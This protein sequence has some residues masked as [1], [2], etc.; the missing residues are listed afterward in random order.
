MND[1]RKVVLLVGPDGSGKTTVADGLV[2]EVGGERLHAWGPLRARQAERPAGSPHVDLPYGRALSLAK[3]PYLYTR[4]LLFW[5]LRIRPARR[6]GLVVVERGWPDLLVDPRRYRLDVPGSLPRLLG[7][8]LPRPDLVAVLAVEPG[9]AVSR[10]GE[11]D[12]AEVERQV[13]AWREL[14]G[15][16]DG[17]WLVADAN[18]APRDVAG[19]IIRRLDQDLDERRPAL[20]LRCIGGP[21]AAG[22]PYR[23]VSRGGRPRWLLPARRGAAGPLRSGLYRPLRARQAIAARALDAAYALGLAG[24]KLLADPE[25]GLAPALREALGIGELEIAAATARK[26]GGER[27]LLAVR[28]S[29]RL[30]A[31]AKVG[32]VNVGGLARERSVLEALERV[33]L[34]N[35]R[36]PRVLACL[37]WEGEQVLVLE[38]LLS[39]GLADREPARPEQAA[40]AEL[41]SLGDA[42]AP[43][44]GAEDGLVP[45]HGDFA[46]WN[47]AALSGERLAVWDWEESRLGLPL[48]DLFHWRT[49]RVVLL[50]AGTAAELVAGA[51]HPDSDLRALCSELGVDPGTAPLALRAYLERGVADPRLELAQEEALLVR[52][53]ALAL[54]TERA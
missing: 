7:R 53:E 22:K 8:L 4:A 50:G 29:G 26:A 2:A 18:E 52:R 36:V 19:A 13:R 16:G 27:V 3:L 51:L 45:V 9:A 46:P 37:D 35:L 14:A 44:L 49:Q 17:R 48:E 40:L 6:R 31:Y 34:R 41:A 32:D 21:S 15:T 23:L 5:A 28:A 11:L 54:L 43:V 10:K 20:A 12:P 24:S 38:P 42:L 25:R 33:P 1:H 39:P 47:C 30:A